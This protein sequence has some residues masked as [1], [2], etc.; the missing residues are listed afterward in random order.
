MRLIVDLDIKGI[1]WDWLEGQFDK[2]LEKGLKSLAEEVDTTWKKF[3]EERLN[4]SR[5][6]YV[7]GI[8]VDVIDKDVQCEL[9]GFVPVAVETGLAGYDM[10]PGLLGTAALRVIPIGKRA[11]ESP[12]LTPLTMN[13]KGWKHPGFQARKI[14]EDV[15]SKVA[16][17]IMPKIFGDMVS[18]MM[19]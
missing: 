14:H 11:G 15:Q 6:Q 10:K 17:E 12:R 13:S 16:D 18:R 8:H 2:E 19:A 9:R 3:A 5:A 7:E 1:D 4:Q